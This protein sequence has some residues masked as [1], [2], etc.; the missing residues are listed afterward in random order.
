MISVILC[1]LLGVGVGYLLTGRKIVA[2]IGKIV[3]IAIYVLLFL[4][5]ILVGSNP[6]VIDNFSNIGVDAL[7]IASASV[8]G[9]SIVAMFIFKWIFQKY[10]P[11][12]TNDEE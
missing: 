2:N 9:S 10:K 8:I 3:S 1:M 5:G 7:I 6:A 12:Q 11:K 4:M